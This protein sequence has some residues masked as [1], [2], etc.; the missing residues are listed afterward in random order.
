MYS[1]IFTTTSRLICSTL[2][3]LTARA[4]KRRNKI[5][6]PVIASIEKVLEGMIFCGGQPTDIALL[7]LRCK[8]RRKERESEGSEQHPSTDTRVTGSERTRGERRGI[9]GRHRRV[10]RRCWKVAESS[11]RV[12]S[13]HFEKGRLE[14]APRRVRSLSRP[15]SSP[16]IPTKST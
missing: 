14:F 4:S 16:L 8:T 1:S 12:R 11:P 9:V 7:F 5:R 3:A 15:P 13:P 2:W 10:C 6:G